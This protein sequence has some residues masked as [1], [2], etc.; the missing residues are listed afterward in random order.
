M[1]VGGAKGSWVGVYEECVAVASGGFE[2]EI[3]G[4][5]RP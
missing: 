4:T 5:C 2:E 1:G 3:D